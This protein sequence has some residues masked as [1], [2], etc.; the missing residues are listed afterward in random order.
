MG[1]CLVFAI[2]T[3]VALVFA[4][5]TARAGTFPGRDGRIAFTANVG[6]RSQVFIMRADGRR[7]T[8]ISHEAAGAA[9][10][11][12]A[13]GGSQLVYARSDGLASFVSATG[14]LRST[15]TTQEP[16]AH[17]ALSPDGKRIVFMVTQDG[18]FDGPSIYVVNLDGTGLQRLTSGSSPQWSPNGHWLAYVSV[19]AD[20]GCSGVRLMQPDGSDDHPVAEGLPDASGACRNSAKMPSFS[21]DSRRVIYVATGIHTPHRTDGTDIYAVSIHGGAHRRLT[22]D[23]L[24]ES[25]PVYSPDGKRVAYERTG[26]HGRQNGVFTISAAGEHRHRIAPPHAG[27]SW[28]PLPGG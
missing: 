2:A 25:S 16:I 22:H 23:D 20:S 8:Q 18:L 28:Q 27:L 21:A 4:A 5:A 19:P 17:P 13:P 1:R 3:A 9:D 15:F 10:P 11:D 6:A 12:W 26:G 24:N 7:R 14:V